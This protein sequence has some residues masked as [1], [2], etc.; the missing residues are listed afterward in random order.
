MNE[1]DSELCML[2]ERFEQR[3]VA[4]LLAEGV[5]DAPAEP[6]YVVGNVVRQIA[7]LGMA[8]DLLDRIEFRGVSGQPLDADSISESLLQPASARPMDLP[9]IHDQRDRMANPLKYPSNE[10]LEVVSHDVVV[11]DVEVESQPM[12]VWRDGERRDDRQPV[13]AIPAIEHGCFA[14]RRPGA[15]D[16]RLQHEARFVDQNDPTAVTSRVFLSVASRT[17]A[18]GRWRPDPV[19][20]PVALASGNSS[21][22][23][24]ADATRPTG[25]SSRRTCARRVPRS[26]E[27]SITRSTSRVCG[28]LA[29]DTS[30]VARTVWARAWAW[31]PDGCWRRVLLF[32]SPHTLSSTETRRSAPLPIDAPPPIARILPSAASSLEN[33]APGAVRQFLFGSCIGYVADF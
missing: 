24:P 21:R 31:A 6:Q 4:L 33:D 15:S 17:S 14:T 18:S 8:P 3:L 1:S 30:V 2:K 12:A 32:L 19:R 20:V 26:G 22:G 29:S 28:G 10:L 23:V 11:E 5:S 25:R 9:A 27:A 13:V 16:H 7:V